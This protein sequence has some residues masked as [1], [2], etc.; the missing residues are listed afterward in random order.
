MPGKWA[1]EVGLSESS[2]LEKNTRLFLWNTANVSV[3]AAD[4]PYAILSF[5]DFFSPAANEFFFSFWVI[6]HL[7]F[8]EVEFMIWY[9]FTCLIGIV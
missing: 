9:G 4:T 1:G 2:W 6:Y 7:E 8:M 3:T 5:G